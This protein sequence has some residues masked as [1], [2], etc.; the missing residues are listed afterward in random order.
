[1][2]RK[3]SKKLIPVKAEV[4]EQA[5][6]RWGWEEGSDWVVVAATVVP[7]GKMVPTEHNTDSRRLLEASERVAFAVSEERLVQPK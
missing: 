1:M 3:N 2:R 4:P 5:R 7:V 6:R